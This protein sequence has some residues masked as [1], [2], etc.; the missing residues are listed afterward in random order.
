MLLLAL[1][2]ALLVQLI[3]YR[4]VVRQPQPGAVLARASGDVSI[5][6][7]SEVER[8]GRALRQIHSRMPQEGMAQAPCQLL[9]KLQVPVSVGVFPV[10]CMGRDGQGVAWPAPKAELLARQ[11]RWRGHDRAR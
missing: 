6:G 5:H 7:F 2:L 3:L 11:H 1:A 10:Q 8:C 4:H 9:S